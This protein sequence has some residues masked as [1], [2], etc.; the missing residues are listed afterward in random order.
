MVS[1]IDPDP[2]EEKEES[3]WNKSFN[4]I[5]RVCTFYINLNNLKCACKTLINPCMSLNQPGAYLFV[6]KKSKYIYEFG[7]VIYLMSLWIYRLSN[8]IIF[9]Y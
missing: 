8:I 1:G 7:L 3:G 9:K 6:K 2:L 5:I 4:S